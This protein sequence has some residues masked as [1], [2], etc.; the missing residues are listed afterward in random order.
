MRIIYHVPIL[1]KIVDAITRAGDMNKKIDKIVLTDKEWQEFLANPKTKTMKQSDGTYE[2]YDVEI[3][4]E[5]IE[6]KNLTYS[7]YEL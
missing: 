2:F 3:T 6:H 7:P 4:S 1:E 5:E